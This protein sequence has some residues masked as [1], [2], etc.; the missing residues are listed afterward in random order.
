LGAVRS[1]IARRTILAGGALEVGEAGVAKGIPAAGPSFIT[2]APAGSTQTLIAASMRPTVQAR[3]AA[4]AKEARGAGVAVVVSLAHPS[5]EAI[6]L[7]R[8]P[9]AI[10][11]ETMKAAGR[12]GGAIRAK[13]SR[14][15]GAAKNF[16]KVGPSWLAKAGSCS[17][18]ISDCPIVADPMWSAVG[19]RRACASEVVF[20]AGAAGVAVIVDPS[21]RAE[22]GSR[23]A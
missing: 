14:K 5:Q 13:K 11:A 22:A 1:K 16:V 8:A 19:A 2:D 4:V 7:A 15:A 21:L 6:A 9:N 20:A 12:A 23:S 10:I 3:G 18:S 17:S